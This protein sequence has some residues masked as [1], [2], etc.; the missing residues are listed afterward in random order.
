MSKLGKSDISLEWWSDFDY[1]FC[2]FISLPITLGILRPNREGR[3]M[4]S[5][6]PSG[7]SCAPN[8]RLS[9]ASTVVWSDRHASR[10]KP[11]A[12]LGWELGGGLGHAGRLLCIVGALRSAG[13]ETIVAAREPELFAAE[14]GLIT[15]PAPCHP[16]AFPAGFI[17]ASYA[18]VL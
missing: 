7:A 16:G 15:L 3:S 13:F 4:Q 11:V 10:G 17:A 5:T 6:I 1:I 9:E 12:L 8:R 14:P 18:D 2:G